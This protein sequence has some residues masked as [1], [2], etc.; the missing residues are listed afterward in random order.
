MYSQQQADADFHCFRLADG[1]KRSFKL[2]YHPDT[3]RP[4][5]NSDERPSREIKQFTSMGELRA[6]TCLIAA[7][8][9]EPKA[10]SFNTML[11]VEERDKC[12]FEPCNISST[13]YNFEVQKYAFR[14]KLT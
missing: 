1:E 2:T 14:L 10:V 5:R 13:F 4:F 6:S 3:L 12:I 9:V 7:T 11:L 8:G